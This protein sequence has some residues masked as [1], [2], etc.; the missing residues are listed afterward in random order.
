MIPK[1]TP[2][3]KIDECRKWPVQVDHPINCCYEMLC[4][5]DENIL[6]SRKGHDKG[7]KWP[8]PLSYKLSWPVKPKAAA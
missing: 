4:I 2:V 5:Q 7:E 8:C 3:W 6:D 1:T